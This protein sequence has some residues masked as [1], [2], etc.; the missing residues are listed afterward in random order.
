VKSA[1]GQEYIFLN[2]N[3]VGALLL[4]YLLSQMAAKNQIPANG[5][6]IKTIVTG[7]LGKK[8]AAS[9]GVETMETLTG[10]KYIGEKMK[11]FD[12]TH[13]RQFIFGYEE[14]YGYLAG[15]FAR[16][17]DAV[18]ISLLLAEM[19]AYYKKKGQSIPEVLE[20]IY[21]KHGYHIESLTSIQLKDS[22]QSAEIMRIFREES[23]ETFG[24][25][26]VWEKRDYKEGVFHNLLSGEKGDTNLPSS[27]VLFFSLEN[28]AWFA[29]RP[30]GTEP[31]IKFYFSVHAEGH[32][33]ATE[34]LIALKNQV[35]S[36]TIY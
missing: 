20:E 17:K 6:M 14:S 4:E 25:L 29:I 2:G 22:S 35:L 31:K 33:E 34:T 12:I 23:A 3:Q 15:T 26:K 16:D 24:G 13:S 1:S 10:F 21:K 8:I 19:T 32:E 11:E 5:V 27:D 36:R 7:N 30:S 18:L 9:Y 28:E